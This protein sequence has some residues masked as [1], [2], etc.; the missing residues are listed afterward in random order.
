[1]EGAAWIP[2]DVATAREL[3][4]ELQQVIA[5]KL[6]TDLMAGLQPKL[7]TRHPS[8]QDGQPAFNIVFTHF[9]IKPYVSQGWHFANGLTVPDDGDPCLTTP[10]APIIYLD[11]ASISWFP[12]PGKPGFLPIPAPKSSSDLARTLAHEYF[13]ALQYSLPSSSCKFPSAVW[14]MEST[15]V[16][17]THYVYPD[18][19]HPPAAYMLEPNHPLNWGVQPG[20][21]SGLATAIENQ[22]AYAEW[23]L[24]LYFQTTLNDADTVHRIWQ[25]VASMASPAAVNAAL[26]KEQ[27]LRA[28]WPQFA[29]ANLNNDATQ[30]L[31]LNYIPALFAFIQ[32]TTSPDAQ[33]VRVA[34]DSGGAVVY[35]SSKVETFT[36]KIPQLSATYA[37]FTFDDSQAGD[38]AKLRSVRFENPWY[39]GS[40]QVQP[41]PDV[42][43]QALYQINGNWQQEDWT[44]LPVKQFCRDAKSE[45]IDDLYIVISNSN[46]RVPDSDTQEHDLTPPQDP[47]LA[48]TNVGCWRW[49]GTVTATFEANDPNY[50]VPESNEPHPN[51][52]DSETLA[53]QVVFERTTDDPDYQRNGGTVFRVIPADSGKSGKTSQV[54]WTMQGGTIDRPDLGAKS[55]TILAQDKQTVPLNS[56]REQPRAWAWLNL[57]NFAIDPSLVRL[58]DT[59]GF[60]RQSLFWLDDCRDKGTAQDGKGFNYW[61]I[62]QYLED[63]KLKVESDGKTIKGSYDVAFGP[64]QM[65]VLGKAHY[66]W[67]FTAERE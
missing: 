40:S 5:P 20:P 53:T 31:G 13:H 3:L 7:S 2:S 44:N 48:V 22:R 9:G 6:S 55:C 62:S 12:R 65:W 28:V 21:L 1:L 49:S 32:F 37:H 38:S 10:A 64:G 14:L 4:R 56:E 45:R 24:S 11:S 67:S 19:Q 61:L 36:A 54:D 15:A 41:D 59:R 30:A 35:D 26:G 39:D 8:P 25:N 23:I 51:R 34:L 57:G 16:W 66:E 47:K 63:R 52:Q 42:H 60:H 58:Y 50:V 29:V 18:F 46:S 43:I 27:G 17:A 33:T